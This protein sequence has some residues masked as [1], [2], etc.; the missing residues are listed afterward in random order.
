MSEQQNLSMRYW[1]YYCALEQDLKR[2]SRFIEFSEDNMSTHSIELTRL[3][4][5]S[6][7]EIDVILKEICSLLDENS[8]VGNINQYR[9]GIKSLLP[10]I[11]KEKVSVG[12]FGLDIKPWENW[13]G[14][15][16]PEWWKSHNNVKHERNIYFTEANLLNTINAICALFICVNYYYKILLPKILN[17]D[18]N[19]NDVTRVLKSESNFIRFSNNNYYDRHLLI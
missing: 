16:N 2:T 11:I 1:N 19:F 18:M 6:C 9:E 10:E 7:S 15:E 17:L 13:N 4:L 5:S 12:F 14:D 3:L 8:A